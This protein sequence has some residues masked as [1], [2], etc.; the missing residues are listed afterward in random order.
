MTPISLRIREL[1]KAKGW[2]QAE[3]AQRADIT[4]A[5]VSRIEGGKVA[6]LDLEV[7]EKLARALDVHPA[8]LIDQKQLP[9]EDRQ[10]YK[11]VDRAV[12]EWMEALGWPVTAANHDFDHGIYAWRHGGVGEWYTLHITRR[13]IEDH[14]PVALVGALNSLKV[15][16]K[17]RE[18]PDAY[19]LVRSSP[20]GA[21]MVVEQLPGPPK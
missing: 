17:L 13:V 9:V 10:P 15:A 21:G 6:S 19:T 14:K 4:Q 18:Q 20:T 16:E 12:R 7:F 8:V 5:T 1:R 11:D 2:S 3:L